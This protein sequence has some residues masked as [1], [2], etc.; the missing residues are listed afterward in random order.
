MIYHRSKLAYKQTSIENRPL[1]NLSHT[2]NR[3][4]MPR[5]EPSRPFCRLLG[6]NRFFDETWRC[7]RR[8]LVRHLCETTV[9][10]SLAC[11]SCS[12][13]CSSCIEIRSE[14]IL[15]EIPELF[16]VWPE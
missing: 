4:E 7:F 3:L 12:R 6:Q 15:F 5:T 13:P 16:Q 2:R 9:V 11:P 14:R 10:E 1:A 8:R